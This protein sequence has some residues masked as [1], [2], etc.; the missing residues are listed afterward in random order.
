M[1][2]PR[3]ARRSPAGRSPRSRSPLPDTDLDVAK[4]CARAG[5]ADV[6]PLT[7]LALAA[8]RRPEHHVARLVADRVHRPPELVRDPRVG[9]IL[10][11]STFPA[12]LDLVRDLG[13]ELEVEAAIVDRPRTVRGEVQPVV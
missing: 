10:E 13:G 1:P 4:A 5:V 3:R 7:G 6:G 11:Q 2:A 12:A 9:R 8:V